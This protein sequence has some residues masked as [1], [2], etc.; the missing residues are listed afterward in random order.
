MRTLKAKALGF[1]TLWAVWLILT[2]PWNAQEAIA[3]AIVALLLS[4]LPLFPVSPLG[5]LKLNPKALAYMVIYAFVFLKALVLSNLD[6]ALRVLHP[7][8]PIAPGIVKVKT[9]LKTPLGRLLLANSITLTPGTIT[10]DMRGEDIFVHW[11]F[12][13]STDAEAATEAIVGGFEKYLEVICG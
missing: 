3:G 12:V 13:A 4:I 6:V 5:D 2:S 10:V 7:K 9:K 11:I 1:L 8:L